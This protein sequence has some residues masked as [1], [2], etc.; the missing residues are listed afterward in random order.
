MTG[1]QNNCYKREAVGWRS[2]WHSCINTPPPAKENN[3]NSCFKKKEK[4][5]TVPLLRMCSSGPPAVE[6]E[7]AAG[8]DFSAGLPRSSYGSFESSRNDRGWA[9]LAPHSGSQGSENNSI[10]HMHTLFYI[11][12]SRGMCI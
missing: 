1:G 12:V 9:P 7:A 4:R 10:P 6:L 3:N 2:P 8:M 5:Q 11:H